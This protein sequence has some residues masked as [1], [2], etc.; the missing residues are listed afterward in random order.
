M[1][2]YYVYIVRCGDGSYYTG[3]TNNVHRRLAEHNAGLHSTA[4]TFERRPVTLVYT[5]HFQY[6]MDAISWEKHVKR[7]SHAKKDALISDERNKLPELSSC[8]NATCSTYYKAILCHVERSRNATQ[9]LL[10]K[11]IPRLRSG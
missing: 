10:R 8:T 4:Y 6:V 11:S 9:R 2:D 1:H 3:I 7:W 5:A